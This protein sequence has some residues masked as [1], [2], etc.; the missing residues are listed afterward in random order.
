MGT[1]GTV[2]VYDDKGAVIC[3]LYRQYDSYLEGLEAGIDD[4]LKTGD[5]KVVNGISGKQLYFNGMEDLAVR[6]ITALKN[7]GGGENNVGNYYLFP[8]SSKDREE[9]NY[10]IKIH[11][12]SGSSEDFDYHASV[13]LSVNG[14][15][16]KRPSAKGGKTF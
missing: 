5:Y 7:K 8:S 11:E 3:V 12:E 6:L 10:E 9:Y 13:R 14:K 4:F 15:P 1:R 16:F 2:R